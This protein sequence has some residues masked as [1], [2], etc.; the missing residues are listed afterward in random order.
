MLK[1][2]LTKLINANRNDWDFFAALHYGR[3]KLHIKFPPSAP[4]QTSIWVNVITTYSI[5][6]RNQLNTR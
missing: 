4:I 5:Y 2:I 1:K 3:T 6:S